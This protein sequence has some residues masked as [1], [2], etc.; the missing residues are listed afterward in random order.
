MKILV[1]RFSSIG[2]IVLCTPVFRWIKNHIPDSE[3][4]FLT[5]SKFKQV[6][7]GNPY[8]DKLIEWEN[9]KQKSQMFSSDYDLIID[10]HN[11]LRTRLVKLRFW[12]VPSRTLSK[13]NMQKM[14]LV[15]RSK[16]NLGKWILGSQ[17]IQRV[18]FGF[19]GDVI[20]ESAVT[21]DSLSRSAVSGNGFS[22]NTFSVANIVSRNLELLT[23]LGIDPMKQNFDGFTFNAKERELDFFI[24]MPQQKIEL[25]QNFAVIVLGGT[26]ATKQMPFELL[27]KIISKLTVQVVLIGGPAEKIVADKLVQAFEERVIDFCGKISLNDSAWVAS[28]SKVVVSG[29]TGMAHIAAA[30]G[31]NLIMVWGNTVPEFGMSPPVKL[32]ANIQ[33]FNVLGL[34]CRPCSKLGYGSCP[35]QHFG[36]MKNQDSDAIRVA[37]ENYL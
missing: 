18:F 21:E 16:G 35:K 24:D 23:N 26:Y 36:C 15:L 33:H 17:W 28:K 19:S 13:Q 25:P 1:V 20:S 29:D 3:V 9:P 37:I 6:V 12:G 10:L 14:A 5:K 32:T 22:S 8:I 30:L 34:D 2:D 4:H 11:N 7:H 31:L 27:E